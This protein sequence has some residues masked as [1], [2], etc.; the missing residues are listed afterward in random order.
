MNAGFHI[1]TDVIYVGTTGKAV[2][3][4]GTLI[5]SLL[6]YWKNCYNY[7]TSIKM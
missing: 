6:N 5:N 3:Q 1:P 2:I 7:K 4:A